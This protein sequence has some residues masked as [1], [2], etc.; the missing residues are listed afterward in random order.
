MHCGDTGSYRVAAARSSGEPFGADDRALYT[1]TGQ[2]G[3]NVIEREYRLD[4]ETMGNGVIRIEFH[5]DDTD[6][7]PA[8]QY[9]T[10]IRYVITPY[11]ED[12]KIIDGDIVRTPIA[13]KSTLTLLGVIRE[14]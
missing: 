8:G 1:V 4:D 14:V 10:E 12:G 9:Q 7:L 3:K 6:D 5:N 13:L 2:D 11:R